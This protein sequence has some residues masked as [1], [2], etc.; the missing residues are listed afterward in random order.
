MGGASIRIAEVD[1]DN[2]GYAAGSTEATIISL[3]LAF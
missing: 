2:A 3:S 1:V